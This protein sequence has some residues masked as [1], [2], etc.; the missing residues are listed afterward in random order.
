MVEY[1][2]VAQS[3][4]WAGASASVMREAKPVVKGEPPSLRDQ[5]NGCAISES[6]SLSIALSGVRDAV[7][8]KSKSPRSRHPQDVAANRAFRRLCNSLIEELGKI[9]V[10]FVGDEVSDEGAEVV[11]EVEA[12]LEELYDRP[13]GQGES[14]KRVVVAVQSQVNN[15]RWDRRHVDFL[16]DVF[17]FLRV[18]YLVN[19][20]TVIACYDAM[21][22]RGLDPFCGTIG[23]PR[24]VKR[25][26]IEEVEEHDESGGTT[27]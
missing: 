19:E 8:A 17:R 3:V 26:R 23:E 15:A 12:L 14:L 10:F 11:T 13:Y 9:D 5:E 16:R 27:S 20:A 2:S 21:K 24:A 4:S 1:P 22:A 25:Y 6:S 7:P 18:R